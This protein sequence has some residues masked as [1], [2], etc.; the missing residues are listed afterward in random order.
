MIIT[1]RS[2]APL[3]WPVFF[4]RNTEKTTAQFHNIKTYLSKALVQPR[5]LSFVTLREARIAKKPKL[6]YISQTVNL[7][8]ILAKQAEKTSERNSKMKKFQS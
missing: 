2:T 1:I 6:K 8:A 4:L 7:V 3:T 5:E